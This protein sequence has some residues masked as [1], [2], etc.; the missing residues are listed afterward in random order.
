MLQM[1]IYTDMK[2]IISHWIYQSNQGG[3][4]LGFSFFSFG[5]ILNPAFNV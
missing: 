5:R 4:S 2:K 3:D 1:D